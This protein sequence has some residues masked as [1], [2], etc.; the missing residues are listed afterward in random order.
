MPAVG[1]SPSPPRTDR[2]FAVLVRET[3]LYRDTRT[4]GCR[5]IRVRSMLRRYRYEIILGV[6]ILGALICASFYL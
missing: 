4:T 6:L 1:Y 3:S 5:F 2:V